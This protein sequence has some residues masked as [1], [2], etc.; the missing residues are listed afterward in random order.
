MQ[1]CDY[2]RKSHLGYF[3]PNSKYNNRKLN[4]TMSIEALEV[5]VK[6]KSP[7]VSTN[8]K[9]QQLHSTEMT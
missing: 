3:S 4:I 1:H 6:R 2:Y 8:L 7:S 9:V 5:F